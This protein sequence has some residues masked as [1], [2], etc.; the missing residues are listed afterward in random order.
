MVSVVNDVG[1][2][3]GFPSIQ[4]FIYNPPCSFY[5]VVV[6]VKFALTLA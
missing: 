3:V 5:M 2:C 1:S 6:V 4:Q